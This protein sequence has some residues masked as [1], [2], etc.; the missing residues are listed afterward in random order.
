MKIAIASTIVPFVNGG[1]RFIVEWTEAKLREAGHEVEHFYFPFDDDHPHILEQTAALRMVDLA[2]GC[3]R[4][5]AIRPPAHVIPHPNK[6]LWFIHHMRFF[7]DLWETGG[8]PRTLAVRGVK[9][10]LHRLDDITLREASRVYTNSRVVSDRLMTYNGL[11]SEPLYP[12][13]WAPERFR[14]DGYGDEILVVC[15][16]EPHKRQTLLIEAMAHTRTAVRLRLCGTSSRPE[17]GAMVAA[18]IADSGHADRITLEDRWITEAEKSDRLAT[19]LAHAYLPEDEDSYGYPTLEAAHSAKATLT[20]TDS[21]GVLEFV[22]DGENGL[23]FEPTPQ[24]AAEA[25]DRLYA[26]RASA[27]RMGEAAQ[28]TLGDMRIDWGRVVEALAS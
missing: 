26:D 24:A 1:A 17:Y 13:I 7:Y 12:P 15:R 14:C 19:C 27:R 16:V 4:L 5:I 8:P 9:E 10:G 2:Q 25:M 22:R 6:V 21:G 3:D 28:G 18:L 11:A 23:V 20:T